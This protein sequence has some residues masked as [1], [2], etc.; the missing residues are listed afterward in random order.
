MKIVINEKSV[1]YFPHSVTPSLLDIELKENMSTIQQFAFIVLNCYLLCCMSMLS[2]HPFAIASSTASPSSS[3]T[4]STSSTSS[5]CIQPFSHGYL[6]TLGLSS[7][8]IHIII[9]TVRGSISLLSL[10]L[11][12]HMIQAT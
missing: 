5:L 2:L 4:S 1:S 6:H 7:S 12:S 11:Y 3:S 9:N 10:A 8:R